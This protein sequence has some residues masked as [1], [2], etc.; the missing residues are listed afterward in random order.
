[1]LDW[2]LRQPYEDAS[3]RIL[4]EM[5]KVFVDFIEKEHIF[6]PDCVV[7]WQFDEEHRK[8]F[9]A[10]KDIYRWWK[11]DPSAKQDSM[12]IFDIESIVLGRKMSVGELDGLKDSFLDM[13]PREDREEWDK[14]WVVDPSMTLAEIF[15]SFDHFARLRT[16]KYLTLLVSDAVRTSMWT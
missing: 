2:I 15:E 1:M 10:Y 8:V 6:E 11:Y 3:E 16:E 4:K 5:M 12:D 9:Q 14:G 7:D 13:L